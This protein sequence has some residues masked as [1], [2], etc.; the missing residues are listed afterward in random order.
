MAA[1]PDTLTQEIAAG[2][3]R[4]ALGHVRR[5]Y[6]GKLDHVMH[7]P[8]DL[9]WPSE[10][11]PVFHGSFDWHSSVHAH[12]ALATIYRRFPDFPESHRVR[13]L[14]DEQ[15]TPEKI[16]GEMDYLAPPGRAGFERP[17]GWA[18]LLML[19]A[20]L[21]RHVTA[22]GKRWAAELA[23]LAG[24]F[25]R[26]FM[27]FLPRATY[28]VRVGT[29][30]NSAFALRLAMEYADTAGDVLL[31]TLCRDSARRWYEG[32]VDCQAWEPGGDDFLS[33]A[34]IEA[35]CMRMALGPEQCAAWLARFLPRLAQRE[36]A[37]LF[38]PAVVSDRTDG[39][40]AHLDGLNLSRAWCWRSL[41]GV[42]AE[43]DPMRAL[44]LETAAVHQ[45]ASLPHV[46]GDY[47]G[48]HWL[49]TFVLLALSVDRRRAGVGSDS[50]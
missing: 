19:H 17:Y 44:A 24:V 50:E 18:W 16:G 35:E 46:T 29:H 10:L 11:H 32:D 45:E 33:S 7:G 22:E 38:S 30:F 9:A 13:E 8:E 49:G 25:A 39:K 23:P 27:D 14:F 20:E 5:E 2:L 26:R 1:M 12:W 37:T 4:T 31:G 42:W 3:A 6:P 41:A 43:G 34:L 28:P 48:E 36:P 40:I 21:E 15:L 47:A